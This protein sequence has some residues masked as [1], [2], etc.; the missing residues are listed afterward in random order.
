MNEFSLLNHLYFFIIL[1]SY[2]T[3]FLLILT[4]S[5]ELPQSGNIRPVYY[6]EDQGEWCWLQSLY[7]QD[8][9]NG[10]GETQNGWN[11]Y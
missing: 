3:V 11:I 6:K 10:D 9:V 4:D 5:P 1:V 7:F 2:L 8:P